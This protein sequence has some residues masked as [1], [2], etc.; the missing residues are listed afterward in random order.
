MSKT[1][2]IS[3]AQ[4][5]HKWIDM[6]RDELAREYNNKWIA[7]LDRNVIDSDSDL[8]AITSRLRKKLGQKYSKAVIEY[9]TN[10]PM[11]MVLFA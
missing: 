4:I 9:V 10:E 8:G 6:K 7:V 11:N 1:D 2:V 3:R 5:N